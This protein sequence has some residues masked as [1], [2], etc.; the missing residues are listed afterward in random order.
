MNWKVINGQTYPPISI[1]LMRKCTC[2]KSRV[3][4]LFH[5]ISEEKFKVSYMVVHCI[6]KGYK[7]EKEKKRERENVCFKGLTYLNF[8]RWQS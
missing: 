2:M 3:V 4:L 8:I 7:L 1:F 5:K 6:C